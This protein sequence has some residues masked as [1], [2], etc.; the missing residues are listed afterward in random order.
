M[1]SEIWPYYRGLY[2]VYTED[3]EAVKKIASWQ[4]CKR[5]CTY[6]NQKGQIFG[7]DLVFPAK[8]YNRVAGSVNLPKKG[9][10]PV[11]VESGRKAAERNCQHKIKG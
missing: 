3:Y 9:K 8:L 10:N 5:S 2:K 6:H 11:L 1:K 4:D 7:W